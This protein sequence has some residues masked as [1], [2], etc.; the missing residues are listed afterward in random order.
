[1]VVVVNRLC[2]IRKIVGTLSLPRRIQLAAVL[3]SEGILPGEVGLHCFPP[4]ANPTTIEPNLLQPSC[5]H[6]PRNPGSSPEEHRRKPMRAC[7]HHWYGRFLARFGCPVHREATVEQ[8]RSTLLERIKT[9]REER[10]ALVAEQSTKQ[11]EK[12][13][14]D[15]HFALRETHR[16]RLRN[17][18]WLMA[19]E[20]AEEALARWKRAAATAR[21]AEEKAARSLGTLCAEQNGLVGE[22]T[23]LAGELANAK[24]RGVQLGGRVSA[25]EAEEERLSTHEQTRAAV[26]VSRADLNL[27]QTVERLSERA[28]YLL[29]QIL[30]LNVEGAE[31]HRAQESV[32]KQR[33]FPPHRDIEVLVEKL[34][35][36]GIRSATTAAQWLAYNFTD[37]QAAA[38]LLASDPARFGGVMFDQTADGTRLREALAALHTEQL[39][40][41]VAPTPEVIA[42]PASSIGEHLV[43]LPRHGAGFN[44]AAAQSEV[45]KLA[46]V[47]TSRNSDLETLHTQLDATKTLCDELDRWLAEFGG[48]KMLILRENLRGEQQALQG[49]LE[50]QQRNNTRQEELKTEITAATTAESLARIDYQK[51]EKAAG[52]IET[53]IERFD[54]DYD[55][56]RSRQTELGSRLQATIGDPNYRKTQ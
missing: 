9:L 49:L 35:N 8:Q 12:N 18:G 43:V 39:A 14:L 31:D 20:V 15:G 34:Q 3:C 6:I 33:L 55:S 25:A 28:A 7:C 51:A 27:P 13:T 11:Q 50:K 38:D 5:A 24:N 1:M 21:E 32:D 4:V 53:F 19:K 46:S 54:I 45:E 44:F 10:T 29:R 40:V 26:E 37:T 56:K 30:R 36:A 42:K 22:A 2:R 41:A 23:Q 47:I 17:E 48:T 52:Q 16:D